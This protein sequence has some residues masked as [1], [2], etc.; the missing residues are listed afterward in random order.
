MRTRNFSAGGHRDP[1]AGDLAGIHAGDAHDGAH[2]EL[3]E[4]GELGVDGEPVLE[5]HAPLA[6]HEERHGK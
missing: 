5:E 4:R 6:D 2:L 1:D 3:P